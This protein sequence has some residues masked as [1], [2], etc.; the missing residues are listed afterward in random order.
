MFSLGPSSS[1]ASP[2]V[3]YPLPQ[4]PLLGVSLPVRLQLSK[5]LGLQTC[6]HPASSQTLSAGF[7]LMSHHQH[8]VALLSLHPLP[9]KVLTVK[10]AV[11][12]LSKQE[13]EEFTMTPCPSPPLND[14]YLFFHS[15]NRQIQEIAICLHPLLRLF[16]PLYH[17]HIC[18]IHLF[19]SLDWVPATVFC[20][21]L[22]HLSALCRGTRLSG[23]ESL[24]HY[25]VVV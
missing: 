11:T 22:C 10:N 2:R 23:F 18:C 17:P 9:L 3:A 16:L 7:S 20:W 14:I 15:F 5:L 25:G 8:L 13:N 19:V 24:F 1:S 21:P 4:D 12:I 6:E